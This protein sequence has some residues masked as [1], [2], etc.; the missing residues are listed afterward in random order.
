MALLSKVTNPFKGTEIKDAYFKMKDFAFQ[1]N[2]G[3]RI[4]FMAFR[5]EADRQ[6]DKMPYPLPQQLT[7][8]IIQGDDLAP[9]ITPLFLYVADLLVGTPDLADCEQIGAGF[10]KAYTDPYGEEHINAYWTPTFCEAQFEAKS[11]LIKIGV[12]ASKEAFDSGAD[13]FPVE[14]KTALGGAIQLKSEESEE[15]IPQNSTL[16][17]FYA[18]ISGLDIASGRPTFYTHAKKDKKFIDSEDC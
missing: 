1:L 6:A 8:V 10:I 17:D 15:V 7:D 4:G 12:F 13:A 5:S 11:A 9:L 3:G 14:A 16:P 2:N 18:F